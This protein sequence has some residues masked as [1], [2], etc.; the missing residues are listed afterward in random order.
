MPVAEIDEIL[1]CIE[2]FGA[3]C[4]HK[5]RAD[6]HLVLCNFGVFNLHSNDDIPSSEPTESL[7]GVREDT[8]PPDEHEND[9]SF[10]HALESLRPL[11]EF[12]QLDT[13]P[14]NGRASSPLL[15]PN[16]DRDS[17]GTVDITSAVDGP[18]EELP[19]QDERQLHARPQHFWWEANG[20][21]V[22]N[23]SPVHMSDLERF[24]LYHYTHRVV[25]LFCV[26]DNNKS[27][28]KTI[29]LPRVLQSAGQ[30][31]LE[32]STSATRDALRNA[33]L[34]ISAFYLSNDSKSRSCS[35]EAVRWANEAITFRGRAIKLL[36]DTVEGNSS[37]HSPP[38]YKELVATMLSMISINV[39]YRVSLIHSASH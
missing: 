16:H 19:R 37:S 3:E 28:W 13:I 23:P 26:I 17:P 15:T 10:P 34:S 30:L 6:D 29:H 18:L 31:S 32:G 11:L 14:S 8:W 20:A 27:P 12:S 35:D 9:I 21:I 4:I 7:N 1:R 25:H 5:R 36:K 38:K 33:L 39:R 24:L 22:R 2:D